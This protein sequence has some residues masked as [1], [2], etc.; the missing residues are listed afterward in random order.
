MTKPTPKTLAGATRR[1][2]ALQKQIEL[3][4]CDRMVLA[5]LA[6][7]G[8]AFYNPL[9]AATAKTLRDEILRRDCKMNP[10]GSPL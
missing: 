10:D 8:P 4:K 2:R 5:M 6:A 7:D 9:T 1:V 3:L